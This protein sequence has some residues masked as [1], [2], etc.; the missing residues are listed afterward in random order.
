MTI[1]MDTGHRCHTEPT[2]GKAEKLSMLSVRLSAVAVVEDLSHQR[3]QCARK[4]P[5]GR[6]RSEIHDFCRQLLVSKN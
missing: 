5:V 3:L 2:A 1:S 4:P 6:R